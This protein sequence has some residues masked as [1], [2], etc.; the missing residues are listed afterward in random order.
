MMD[1]E[2]FNITFFVSPNQIHLPGIIQN[3]ISE[4][5][6]K[7]LKIYWKVDDVN[8]FLYMINIILAHT[9]VIGHEHLLE[10]SS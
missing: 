1:L 3:K 6:I 4:S 9:S 10:S 5:E 7:Q 2:Q 8:I